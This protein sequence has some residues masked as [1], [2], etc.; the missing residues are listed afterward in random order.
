MYY[1]LFAYLLLTIHGSTFQLYLLNEYYIFIL[2]PL[3]NDVQQ[4]LAVMFNGG[5]EGRQLTRVS[6]SATEWCM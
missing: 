4:N 3:L 2:F 6:W 5:C 1:K